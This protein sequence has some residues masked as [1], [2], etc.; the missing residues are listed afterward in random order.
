MAFGKGR[1]RPHEQISR[2]ESDQDI[3]ENQYEEPNPTEDTPTDGDE[4]NPALKPLLSEVEFQAKATGKNPGGAKKWI[5]K[6]CKKGFTSSYTR[7]HYHFLGAPPGKKAQIQRCPVLMTNK[8]ELERV[9]KIVA[10]AEDKGIS[11]S[12]K[13]STIG[14]SMKASPN[15]KNIADS[16]RSMERH[17]VDLLVEKALCANGIP[18]NVLRSPDFV[19]M[20]RG[21]N[22]APKDYKLPSY[23]K[24]RTTLL[25]ECKRDIEKK[26]LPLK[27]TWYTHGDSIISDGWANIKHKP[28]LNV[29]A[30]NSRGFMFL[31]AENYEGTLICAIWHISKG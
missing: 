11:P 21:I 30:S 23:D 6:H 17:S 22:H 16:F 25:D 14:N 26:L 7:I 20:V 24:A 3:E 15:E 31:Y 10:D 1:K 9:R 29:I 28:L 13:S 27:D 19:E 2:S 12:L 18:F 4:P 5:C 8:G